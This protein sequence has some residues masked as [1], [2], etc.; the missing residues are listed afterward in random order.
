MIF[1]QS[2]AKRIVA[3]QKVQHRFPHDR[4]APE[5]VTSIPVS[6]R[7]PNPALGFRDGQ[8]RLG[9]VEACRIVV[10]HVR[11][12]QLGDVTEADARAEGFQSRRELLA[13]WGVDEIADELRPVNVWVMRFRLDPTHRA[14]LL[15]A[16]VIA[17]HQGDYTE[18]PHRAMQDEPESVD[19]L[20]LQ[21]FTDEARARDRARREG[22]IIEIDEMPFSQQVETCIA[23]ARR[24]HIDI[25]S[26]L[27]AMFRFTDPA[28]KARKLDQIRA[29]LEQVA[30]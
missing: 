10:L 20:T 14:R 30:A 12:G 21:A 5:P 11:A 23:E 17:G 8:P 19:P 25:R 28:I 1:S 24:R 13:V 29:K 27:R 26:E 15:S 2:E 4:K 22:R 3:G 16:R 6:Y 7:E 18:N 9:T